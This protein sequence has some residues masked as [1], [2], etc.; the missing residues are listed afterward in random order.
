VELERAVR[1]PPLRP[2]PLLLLLLL[3]ALGLPLLLGLPSRA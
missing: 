1:P 3:V 2:P